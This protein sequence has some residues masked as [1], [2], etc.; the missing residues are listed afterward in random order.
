MG[1][2]GAGQPG[3]PARLTSARVPADA[4][5]A[6]TNRAGHVPTALA[7]G[8]CSTQTMPRR[9]PRYRSKQSRRGP[10]Q[11]PRSHDGG[12]QSG[13]DDDAAYG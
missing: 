10:R 2:G 3:N 7:C 4:K 1:D 9:K 13:A 5:W 12:L 6:T 8:S 11:D